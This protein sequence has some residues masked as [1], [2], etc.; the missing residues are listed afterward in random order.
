MKIDGLFFRKYSSP[1]ITGELGAL[2]PS[3]LLQVVLDFAMN[4]ILWAGI[5]ILVARLFTE[6]LGKWNVFFV[7]IG[8]SFIAT[9]V[10]TLINLVP[11]STLPMLNVPMDINALNALLDVTWRPLLAYQL[12]LYIPIIGEVWIAAL[13]AIAVHVKKEMTWSKAATIAAVAFAIRF[14]LRLFIGF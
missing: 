2:L 8:Y 1:I 12:W 4:W 13:G 14:L 9:A 11:L 6:D 3:I 10:Y 7:V 5:L